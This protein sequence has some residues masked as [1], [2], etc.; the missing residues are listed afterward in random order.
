MYQQKEVVM[1]KLIGIILLVTLVAVSCAPKPHYLTREGKRK[2]KYYN[3]VY[4]GRQKQ[5]FRN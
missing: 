4:Y 1:K 3:D 5:D 2:I